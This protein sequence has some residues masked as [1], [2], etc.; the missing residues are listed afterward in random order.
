M[1]LLYQ[2]IF[3][4][5]ANTTST[6]PSALMDRMEVGVCMYMCDVIQYDHVHMWCTSL[7]YN[8]ATRYNIFY[9]WYMY[10]V[11]RKRKRLKL[12]PGISS[13]NNYKYVNVMNINKPSHYSGN[14][15]RFYRLNTSLNGSVYKWPYS[16]FIYS[17]FAHS[18]TVFHQTSWT[19]WLT[20]SDKW[21]RCC[22]YTCNEVVILVVV[23]LVNH[24]CIQFCVYSTWLAYAIW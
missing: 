22:A 4:A 17:S 8:N 12:L 21:V 14:V 1:S 9:R 3:I 24:H 6:I 10:Q 20:P 16:I 13:L 7:L 19:C 15:R 11:T 5:T 2:V 23:F 18:I